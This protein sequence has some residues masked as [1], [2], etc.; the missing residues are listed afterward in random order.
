M[1]ENFRMHWARER[2]RRASLAAM[3]ITPF[4][5]RFDAPGAKASERFDIPDEGLSE[6]TPARQGVTERGPVDQLRVALGRRDGQGLPEVESEAT[7]H[8]TPAIKGQAKPGPP[9]A[10]ENEPQ[11]LLFVNS[12]DVLWVE[13]LEDQLLRQEQLQL[14]AAMARA[15][16]GVSVRCE[17]QQFEWPPSGQGALAVADNGMVEVL[18]GFLQRLTRDYRI[19]LMVLMGDC[20]CLPSSDIPQYRIPSSLSMLRDGSLKETAWAILKPLHR[21]A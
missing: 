4:V 11:S 5:S 14:V 9:A 7:N 1:D 16:R 2:A 8:V 12:G 21:S 18:S 6:S 17:H 10:A 13:V 15:I 19:E 20:D 3:G